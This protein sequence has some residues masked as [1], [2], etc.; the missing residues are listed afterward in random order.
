[1]KYLLDNEEEKV[2]WFINKYAGNNNILK[3]S[4]KILI[5]NL[6]VQKAS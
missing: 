1:M 5:D 2:R 6:E 4:A 3:A